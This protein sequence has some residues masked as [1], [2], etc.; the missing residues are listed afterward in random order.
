M[1][2]PTV[3]LPCEPCGGLALAEDGIPC[4]YC[5]G[6]G[7]VAMHEAE[8]RRWLAWTDLRI[9]HGAWLAELPPQLQ[10]AAALGSAQAAFEVWA[11]VDDV[12]YRGPNVKA[13][14][15]ACAAYLREPTAA[16]REAWLSVSLGQPN[17]V[18]GGASVAEFPAF[19][20]KAAAQLIGDDKAHDAAR[21]GV[22][23]LLEGRL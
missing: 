5:E 18:P 7:T 10:I 13:V 20:I 17:W 14:L 11:D 16:R 1:T 22:L 12:D 9:S 21:E 8:L 3:L 23:T 19:A 6:T 2:N 15:D 4:R